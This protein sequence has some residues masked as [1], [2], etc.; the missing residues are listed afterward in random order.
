M[1]TLLFV[2]AFSP[3][4]QKY[5]LGSP[6]LLAMTEYFVRKEQ[7]FVCLQVKS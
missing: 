1:L 6:F 7:D 2:C 4:V 5:L 3:K